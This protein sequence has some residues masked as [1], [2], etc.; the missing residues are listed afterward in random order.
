MQRG[1]NTA[2]GTLAD[3]ER[4][5]WVPQRATRPA[6]TGPGDI[7]F[8]LDPF[9]D[10]PIVLDGVPV[11]FGP[12]HTVFATA[13]LTRAPTADDRAALQE[14]LAAI[15]QA[16][17][18]RPDGVFVHLAYGVPYF[19]RLAPGLRALHVPR[20]LADTSRFVL[21]EA[22]PAPTDVH[23]A[24]PHV[25]KPM[26]HLPVRIERNDL[27]LTLRGDDPAR[28]ADVLGW[29]GGSGRLAGA[30]V[31]SPR[32]GLRFTTSR[33]MFVQMGLPR[34][35]AAA[36]GLP[37]AGQLHPRAEAWLGPAEHHPPSPTATV[38]FA[39]GLL[40]TAEPGDY[41]D[42]GAIQHLSHDIVDLQHFFAGEDEAF[43][44]QVRCA[45]QAPPAPAGRRAAAMHQPVQGP[46]FDAMD[47]PGGARQPKLQF[48]IFV[49]TSE[50]CAAGR[51]REAELNLHYLTATRRQNFL[52]PPRR[53][54]CYP[55]AEL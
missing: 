40:T 2:L 39:G 27:L 50:L 33:A 37:F 30:R 43:T 16:Y 23:P 6:E 4:L 53:H 10:P 24:N 41:F 12:I 17:P 34:K 38:T 52:V 21:E 32:L 28:L 19:R 51:A 45:F 36:H 35:L 18:W 14:A 9:V 55:L 13:R 31:A 29:L 8:D 20:L 7:Q 49:P 46:G 3:L 1:L 25:R 15:E 5:A 54:R 26:F 11:R 22:Q 48:S 47:V 42:N 44:E